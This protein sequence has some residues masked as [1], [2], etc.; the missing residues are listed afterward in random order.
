MIERNFAEFVDHDS[1][2]RKLGLTEHMAEYRGLTTA[3]KAGKHRNW[4]KFCSHHDGATG[5]SAM[6]TQQA[7]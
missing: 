7:A 3:E 2:V 4:N 6:R 1:G 5:K